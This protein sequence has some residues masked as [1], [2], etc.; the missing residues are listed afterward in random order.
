MPLRLAY[1]FRVLTLRDWTDRQGGREGMNE[2]W[3]TFDCAVH[4]TNV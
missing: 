2:C 1:V 3:I 4:A